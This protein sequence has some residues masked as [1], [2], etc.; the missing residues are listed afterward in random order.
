MNTFYQLTTLTIAVI[1]I[2]SPIWTTY[3]QNR[4]KLRAHL[5]D[6]EIASLTQRIKDKQLAI[7]ELSSAY[8]T[9]VSGAIT[10]DKDSVLL[11]QKIVQCAQ[12]LDT[13]LRNK[14]L[15]FNG[16]NSASRQAVLDNINDI[17][18]KMILSIHDDRQKL[19]D[20]IDK[21]MPKNLIGKK[22]YNK[23]FHK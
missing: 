2:I 13:E 22:T 11:F 18:D 19:N 20:L 3:L 17:M 14:I 15:S 6:S 23:L 9:I 5:L 21:R 1:A 8:G 10:R 12:Y 7:K 4:N 16:N